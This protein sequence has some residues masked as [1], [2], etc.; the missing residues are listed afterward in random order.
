MFSLLRANFIFMLELLIYSDFIRWVNKQRDTYFTSLQLHGRKQQEALIP[1]SLQL[2]QLPYFCITLH[3]DISVFA[4]LFKNTGHLKFALFLH[5]KTISVCNCS[6]TSI[7]VEI[8]WKHLLKA[9]RVK[10]Y[11]YQYF[12]LAKVL[13]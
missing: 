12:I 11:P 10:T 5:V 1:S 8:I 4:S 2:L 13:F 9:L 3:R 7:C 6:R